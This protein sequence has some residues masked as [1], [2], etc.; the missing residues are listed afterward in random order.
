MLYVSPET[1]GFTVS[2]PEMVPGVA[3]VSTTVIVTSEVEGVQ[4]R[5]E[6]LQCLE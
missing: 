5:T 3:G 6:A 2:D 4:G 1:D